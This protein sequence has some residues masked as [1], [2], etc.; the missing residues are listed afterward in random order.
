MSTLDAQYTDVGKAT[1]IQLGDKFINAPDSGYSVGLQWDND[2]SGGGS[3]M[4]RFDYGWIDSVETFRDRRFHFS[5]RANDAYGLASGRIT[6]TPA[7]G[8]W[9]IAFLGTNLTN[10]YYRQGGFPA[11]LAGIDQGVVGRPREFGVTIRLRLE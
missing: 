7:A 3:V 2:L 9:D 4:A 6:Y 1:T 10:E 11:V 8:N 5:E